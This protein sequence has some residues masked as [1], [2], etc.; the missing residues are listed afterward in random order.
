MSSWDMCV[1]WGVARCLEMCSLL[2]VWV[3]C[4][5]KLGNV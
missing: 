5:L 4:S 3:V 2:A 1:G